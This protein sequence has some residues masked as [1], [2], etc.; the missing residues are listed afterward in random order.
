MT[1][2]LNLRQLLS[3]NNIK[4]SA[5]PHKHWVLDSLIPDLITN[6]KNTIILCVPT[7]CRDRHLNKSIKKAFQT[8]AV[9]NAFFYAYLF[10]SN[11]FNV[12]PSIIYRPCAVC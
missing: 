10:I 3:G 7:V 4:N 5:K 12:V 2:L 8:F 11:D 9:G 1:L 6:W